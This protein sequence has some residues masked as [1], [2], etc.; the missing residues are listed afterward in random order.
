MAVS[1]C[2]LLACATLAREAFHGVVNELKQLRD[3]E[4]NWTLNGY[5]A[6]PLGNIDE[7]NDPASADPCLKQKLEAN[8]LIAMKNLNEVS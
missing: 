7:S 5:L 4:F 6:D 3:E 8:Q 1:I 2:W